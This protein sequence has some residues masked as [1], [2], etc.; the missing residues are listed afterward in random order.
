MEADFARGLIAVT[1]LSPPEDA[2]RA[3]PWAVRVRSLGEFELT[4]DGAAYRPSHK[5]QDK[6]LELLKLLICCHALGRPSADKDWIVE[7]LWPD[8][9]IA[10]ARKS[11]DMTVSRLRRLLRS[12]PATVSHE[13]PPRF[14]PRHVCLD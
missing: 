3:W 4:I 12:E 14:P 8:A 6:P 9:D 7:R 10:N 11:L 13:G 5:A 1:R 2:G